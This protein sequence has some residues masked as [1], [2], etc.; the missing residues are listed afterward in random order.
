MGYGLKM[1]LGWKSVWNHAGLRC[2]MMDGWI[3]GN[4]EK[5]KSPEIL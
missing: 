3:M 1:S 5:N 2:G 4:E